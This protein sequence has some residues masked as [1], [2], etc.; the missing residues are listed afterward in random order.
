MAKIIFGFL[1]LFFFYHAAEYMVIK[2]NNALGFLVFQALFF[3]AAS[4]I[5]RWQGVRGL[6]AW[7]I[8]FKKRMVKNLLFGLLAGF[9]VYGFYFLVSLNLGFEQIESVPETRT[10]I[11]SFLL[12]TF[13]T[14]FSSLSEDVLTRS[15]IYKHFSKKIPSG[16]LLILSSA[17]YVINHI[18]RLGDGFQVLLYLFIIGLFLMIA[19]MVTKNI[20]LTLGLHWSGNIVYQVTNNIIQTSSTT[21]DSKQLWLYIS[22]LVLL[23]PLTYFVATYLTKRKSKFL[24]FAK[25]NK[26]VIHH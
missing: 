20:W 5:A 17:L 23:I 4:L 21:N 7:G 11:Q 22:F 25:S 1:L 14:F 9:F 8:I 16:V 13:G 19:L 24:S 10:F 3:V 26:K 15:Y 6:S 2:E 12:L 18:Y